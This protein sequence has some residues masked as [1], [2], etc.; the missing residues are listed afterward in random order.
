M[1]RTEIPE[2]ARKGQ[3][4]EVNY[5]DQRMGTNKALYVH[6]LACPSPPPSKASI[7]R[8]LTLQELRLGEVK[9][10]PRECPVARLR[11]Q[12]LPFR[13]ASAVWGLGQSQPG[14]PDP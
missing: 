11:A 9:E 5:P 8:R 10:L 3:A 7:I 1:G 6:Y 13:L 4:C 2:P 12:P 14:I